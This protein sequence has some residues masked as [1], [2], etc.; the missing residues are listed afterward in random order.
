MILLSIIIIALDIIIVSKLI[1]NI[2]LNPISIYVSFWSIAIIANI[3][4]WY[5]Y[6]KVDFWGWLIITFSILYFFLGSITVSLA[7]HKSFNNRLFKT[8]AN[9]LK[10]YNVILKISMALCVISLIGIVSDWWILLQKFGDVKSVF[11]NAN[12]IYTMRVEGESLQG[13]P[14]L[15]SLSLSSSALSGIYLERTKRFRFLLIVPFILVVLGALASMGRMTILMAILLYINPYIINYSLKIKNSS[16]FKSRLK[17]LILLITII[18][19]VLGTSRIR[20]VR[21]GNIE[22]LNQMPNVLKSIGLAENRAFASVYT[23]ISGPIASFSWSLNRDRK[24]LGQGPIPGMQTISPIFRLIGKTGILPPVSYY[25]IS[26]GGDLP[27]VGTYLKDV[28]I[29]FGL[30]GVF[31]IPYFLGFTIMLLFYKW[32]HKETIYTYTALSFMYL[33]VEFSPIMNLFRLG[34]Y[35]MP[36]IVTVFLMYIIEHKIIKNT[37]M[38]IF[39]E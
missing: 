27:N 6:Q 34:Y 14:Y 12:L 3:L 29:D 32:I 13:I 10:K 23:N 31:I 20:A 35:I 25:E 33:F 30:L 38:E 5:G 9:D 4:S 39:R 28:Y 19:L 16:I 36:F 26:P 2:K 11:I 1:T 18:A 37:I 8:N 22:T 21:G 15:S 24:D 17:I 7:F